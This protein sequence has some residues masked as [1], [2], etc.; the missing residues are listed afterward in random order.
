MQPSLTSPPDGGRRCAFCGYS[1]RGEPV[2][3]TDAV[4]CTER[5]RE[6][7]E[8]GDESFRGRHEFK[9]FAT[10]VSALDA[11]LPEGVPANS[12]VLLAGVEGI[13]HRGL[14]TELAWRALRRG[15]PAVV[16]SYVDPPI[17]V[18]EHFLTFGWNVLP[19]AERGDLHVIDCY[20][21]RLREEHRTPD[22]QV[23]WN[24]FL[25]G[26][27]SESVTTVSDPTNLRAVESRLH[28]RLNEADMLGTGLV[29]V[30]SL[31]EVE[32]QSGPRE[33]EQF[34]K[35]VRGDVCSRKYV[36]IFAGTTTNAGESFVRDH[37]YLFDG[38]VS[39]RHDETLVEGASLKQLAVRKM[40][41]VRYHPD[42]L[43]YEQ[44]GARGFRAFDPATEL[45][46]TYG[47]RPLASNATGIDASR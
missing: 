16:V 14:G 27:L 41:G 31:N 47:D 38:I 4:F 40:D 2:P 17:A 35:E 15:E 24:D 18:L 42:W 33:T 1:V 12:F 36:P 21:N 28:S 26:F 13:R 37:A 23:A 5:C 22:R 3:G 19:Y 34:V 20:T 29:V 25:G 44:A 8:S 10:G 9:R 7:T 43:A 30:D 39:M 32:A 45:T 46:S 11:L 6:A